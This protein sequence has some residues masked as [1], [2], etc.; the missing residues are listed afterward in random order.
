MTI[1]AQQIR[2]EAHLTV[3]KLI[4]RDASIIIERWS[5]RVLQEQPRALRVHHEALLD[6]LPSFLHDVGECLAENQDWEPD[7]HWSNARQHGEQRWQNGWSLAEVIQDYQILRF[8]VVDYLEETMDRHLR[9]R[10]IMA[11][12]L[13]LDEAI[14]ASVNAYTAA[15]QERADRT[16]RA[17]QHHAE[18]LKAT[19]RRKDEFLAILGH[20]M[21]NPLGPIRNAVE[22]LA[23]RGNDQST[24]EWV[25]GMLARQVRIMTRLVDDLL[26]ASR[27]GRGKI[28]LQKERLDL[29]RLVAT[30]TEDMQAATTSTGPPITVELPTG[31]VWVDGDVTR[32]TQI[33]GNLLQNAAK[34]TDRSGRVTVRLEHQE[35]APAQL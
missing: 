5:R 24:V 10:E 12:G 35:K 29:V 27:V 11:I 30:V 28:I 16:D 32:L 9:A 18:L 3:G 20:E 17:V 25:R 2:A 1:N 14:T 23:L 34:F 13:A 15:S 26:D 7:K 21:R 33:I 22:V 8:V 4:Q 31:P 6:H 19:N